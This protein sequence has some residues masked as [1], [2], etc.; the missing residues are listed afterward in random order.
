MNDKANFFYNKALE[1]FDDK[2]G[3]QIT[4]S[5]VLDEIGKKI[6]REPF[7]GVYPVDKIP[8]LNEG[9]VCVINVDNSKLPGSHWVGCGMHDNRLYVYDSFGRNQ[10]KLKN[11]YD[12][13]MKKKYKNIKEPDNDAEQDIKENNCGQRS[14]AWIFVFKVLGPDYSLYV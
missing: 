9:D 4:F 7:K 10:D 11:M 6:F 1:Y 3:N 12:L 14:L 8:E 5:N 13:L 2:L